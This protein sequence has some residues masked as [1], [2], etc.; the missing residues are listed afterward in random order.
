M[1]I[2]V[3]I[4]WI[5]LQKKAEHAKKDAMPKLKQVIASSTN[6]YVPLGSNGTLRG[7]VMKNI[8]S[9]EPRLIWDTPYA[10]FQW[11]GEVMVGVRSHSPWAKRGERKVYA[12][13][14]LKYSQGGK[15]WF[16][17]AKAA[18]LDAWVKAVKK[19][20]GRYFE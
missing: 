13:R 1:K 14:P 2:D 19:E 9:D 20:Y 11:Y 4:D 15:D 7:S 6:K 3:D 5:A 18:N 17:R 10:H 8:G 12:G 16:N